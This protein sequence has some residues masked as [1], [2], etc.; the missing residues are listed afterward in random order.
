[1]EQDAQ[2]CQDDDR[3]VPLILLILC[4][5]LLI[6]SYPI[7]PLHPCRIFFLLVFRLQMSDL[8][9]LQNGS[10]RIRPG[11]Q[12]KVLDSLLLDDPMVHQIVEVTTE[13]GT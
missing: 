3:T 1:M 13:S 6:S 11:L 8:C 7:Y 9:N 4:I 12:S 2:D 10:L 5:L